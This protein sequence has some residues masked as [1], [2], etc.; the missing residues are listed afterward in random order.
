[1][2]LV[3][4]VAILTLL[5]TSDAGIVSTF[6]NQPWWFYAL[7]FAAYLGATSGAPFGITKISTENIMKVFMAL[8]A[9]VLVRYVADIAGLTL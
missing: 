8:V 9:I 1:M 7:P 4:P 3:V 5:M 2:M 6:A